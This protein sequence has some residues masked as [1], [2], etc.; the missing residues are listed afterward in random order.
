MGGLDLGTAPC[1]AIVVNVDTGEVLGN[2]M[3]DYAHGTMSEQLPDGT[4]LGVGFALQHPLDYTQAMEQTIPDAIN[5]SGVELEQIIG[6]GVSFTTSTYLPIRKDLTPLCVLT[7][8]QGNPHAYVK[9]WKHHS[10]VHEAEQIT[11]V[12]LERKEKWSES[13]GNKINTEYPLCKVLETLHQSPEVYHAA[14]YYVEAGD[15]V[16]AL[17]CG[18]LKK[19]TCASTYKGFCHWETGYPCKEFCTGLHEDLADYVEKMLDYPR[20]AFD[21][22]LGRVSKEAA[23]RFGLPEGCAVAA[24]IIDSFAAVGGSGMDKT[25]CM[26]SVMGTSG[27]HMLLANDERQVPG[28][29]GMSYSDIYPG[30]YNYESGQS[31]VGDLFNWYISNGVPE[32]YYRQAK[33]RGIDLHVL[34]TEKASLLKPAESGILALDWWNGNRSILMN[35][36]LTGMLLGMTLQSKPEHIYRA[37]LEASAFSTRRIIENYREH[38]IDIREVY[39]TGGISQKNDLFMQIYADVLRL[40]I[41]VCGGKFASAQGSAVYAAVAAGKAAGGYD[42]VLEAVRHI[43]HKDG[44][45]FLPDKVSSETYN[46]LY[47]EYAR[48]YD[49]FGRGMNP[50]MERLRMYQEKAIEGREKE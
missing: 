23:K 26:V 30:Y 40:P 38:G 43:G 4:P 18:E 12:V 3:Y 27:C 22:Q 15:W 17:L 2:S 35:F 21:E 31:C 5:Q 16:T 24:Y 1:R 39:V 45:R 14:D 34:L 19:S 50:V 33:E 42:D 36:S 32:D 49:Y 7:E 46:L 37:L 13:Y 29:F 41:Q 25:N 47:T 20:V 9:L 6:V 44:K 48:L 11:Q 28:I 10:P 8:Y